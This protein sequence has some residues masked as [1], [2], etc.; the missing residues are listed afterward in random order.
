MARPKK[1]AEDKKQA[2]QVPQVAPQPPQQHMMPQGTAPQAMAYQNMAPQMAM[3]QMPQQQ[4][5][6]QP[7]HQFQQFA[8]QVQMPQQPPPPQMP[9]Q[10]IPL[11]Q[12][13]NVTGRFVDGDSFLSVRDS[14]S[15][16]FH[17][18][19]TP[20]LPTSARVSALSQTIALVFAALLHS[21]LDASGAACLHNACPTHP[22][23]K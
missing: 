20:C 11:P 3:P 22:I 5:P 1:S 12:Q 9:Q 18:F 8:P 2:Q 23:R 10:P 17:Y 15:L 14:V 6:R 13:Q 7:Q 4:M 16:Y 19:F 21:S